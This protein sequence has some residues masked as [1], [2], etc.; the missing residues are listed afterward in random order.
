M[1]AE[2]EIQIRLSDGDGK[3]QP[4]ELRRARIAGTVV[5]QNATL[6]VAMSRT[7]EVTRLPADQQAPSPP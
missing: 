1:V 3:V 5:S 7:A 6:P 4:K 2:E